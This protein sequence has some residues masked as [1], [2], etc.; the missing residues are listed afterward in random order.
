MHRLLLRASRI[1]KTNSSRGWEV[2]KNQVHQTVSSSVGWVRWSDNPLRMYLCGCSGFT[3]METMLM[4]YGTTHFASDESDGGVI[5][6]K[7]IIQQMDLLLDLSNTIQT[8][9]KRSL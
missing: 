7:K 4:E 3:H 1:L 2:G 6:Q 9:P 5:H 8:M